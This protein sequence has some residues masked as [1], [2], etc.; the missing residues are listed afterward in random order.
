MLKNFLFILFFLV[1]GVGHAQVLI[2]E[3]AW[4]GTDEDA[5]NEWIELYN[6]NSSATDLTG[7][8]LSD[9]AS[10]N[11]SL[12]GA[13]PSHGVVVL[14]RS[15]DDTLPGAAFAIYT[16][17]L[18]NGGG[19][20]T[21]RDASGIISDQAVGG[22]GWAG[23]GGSNTV[24]KKTPQRTRTGSWV[25]GTPTPNAENAQEEAAATTTVENTNAETETVTASTRIVS[26]GGGSSS[27]KTL[28]KKVITDPV[29]HLE[30]D[31]PHIAYVNQ[32]V[33]F[34]AIPSGVGK[35]LLNSLSY[36]WNFGD[37][38]GAAGKKNTHIFEY[39]GEYIVVVEGTFAKQ[40]A[41][42]RHEIIVYPVS[43]SLTRTAR[44]DV[45]IKNNAKQEVDLS[46]FILQGN[47]QF[48]FPR[49]T[50]IKPTGSLTIAA[51]R[52]GARAE[53]SLVLYDTQNSVIVSTGGLIQKETTYAA[54][55]PA[56]LVAPAATTKVRE[57][58]PSTSTTEVS[59]A[60]VPEGTVATTYIPIGKIASESESSSQGFFKLVFSRMAGFFGM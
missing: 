58:A 13:I 23:I 24:P 53:D 35:T 25:T 51:K 48:V 10:I 31:A 32:E 45:V 14:E 1:P 49:L 57:V 34:E 5:N 11:V 12:T 9:G 54:A 30:V 52:I 22:T 60:T 40:K 33:T 21:L 7:W 37:T 2:S 6:L 28:I 38:Y 42:V 46:G 3:V 18:A 41:I 29:L 26:S 8:T 4:M 55:V 47:S 43:V 39:P 27:K 44:G 19:T 56:S 59:T 50:F 16:G 15:D 17:A 20:L 36:T